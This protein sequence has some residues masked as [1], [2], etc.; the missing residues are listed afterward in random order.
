MSMPVHGTSILGSCSLI[1]PIFESDKKE[2]CELIN[3]P[4]ILGRLEHLAHQSKRRPFEYNASFELPLKGEGRKTVNLSFY[5]NVDRFLTK[6]KERLNSSGFETADRIQFKGGAIH[7]ILDGHP[8]ELHDF[9]VGLKIISPGNPGDWKKIHEIILVCMEDEAGLIRYENT[10]EKFVVYKQKDTPFNIEMVIEVD[11]RGNPRKYL[12]Q[13]PETIKNIW[14]ASESFRKMGEE[15]LLY[16]I[17]TKV[18]NRSCPIE[19]EIVAKHKNSATCSLDA[20]RV[21]YPL[22]DKI[23]PNFSA[24]DGYDAKLILE[25]REKGLFEVQLQRIP[26]IRLGFLRYN[27]ILMKGYLPTLLAFEQAYG[28][29]LVKNERAILDIEKGLENYLKDHCATPEKQ[30]LYL[31][32]SYGTLLRL[33]IDKE[34][35]QRLQEAYGQILCK[36]LDVKENVL[37]LVEDASHLIALYF[38]SFTKEL[39]YKER[40]L[41]RKYETGQLTRYFGSAGKRGNAFV[42]ETSRLPD[43][44]LIKEQLRKSLSANQGLKKICAIVIPDTKKRERLLGEINADENKIKQFLPSISI[45]DFKSFLESSEIQLFP[46]KKQARYLLDLFSF[47]LST[48]VNLSVEQKDGLVKKIKLIIQELKVTDVLLTISLVRNA[49]ELKV[50]SVKDKETELIILIGKLIEAEDF[51]EAYKLCE[52]TAKDSEISFET[53]NSIFQLLMKS[54]VHLKPILKFLSEINFK[55][56]QLKDTIKLWQQILEKICSTPFSHSSMMSFWRL[57]AIFGNDC[58]EA[59]VLDQLVGESDQIIEMT[60]E[61]FKECKDDQILKWAYEVDKRI[62]SPCFEKQ[63]GYYFESIKE[64]CSK[65]LFEGTLEA[66]HRM[67]PLYL[68]CQFDLI[69]EDSNKR[70]LSIFP[71]FIKGAFPYSNEE[72]WQA[73][74]FGI[75]QFFHKSLSVQ[76]ARN[77]FQKLTDDSQFVSFPE[78]L[79]ASWEALGKYCQIKVEFKYSSLGF[80]RSIET[81]LATEQDSDFE[82]C[83][84]I[85]RILKDTLKD[86]SELNSVYCN[87]IDLFTNAL[88]KPEKSDRMMSLLQICYPLLNSTSLGEDYKRMHQ[89]SGVMMDKIFKYFSQK[90]KL[91]AEQLK[92]ARKQ[93]EKEKESILAKLISNYQ[94]QSLKN[95]KDPKIWKKLY[96]FYLELDDGENIV[97]AGNNYL[98]YNSSKKNN[99]KIIQGIAYGYMLAGKPNESHL[100][101]KKLRMNGQQNLFTDYY[102]AYTFYIAEKEIPEAANLAENNNVLKFLIS[103]LKDGL[104]LHTISVY[105]LCALEKLI[106]IKNKSPDLVH[107]LKVLAKTIEYNG[108]KKDQKS[109]YENC[110]LTLKAPEKQE[111]KNDKGCFEEA[112]LDD[113]SKEI[114]KLESEFAKKPKDSKICQK[115]YGCYIK[116]NDYHNIIRIAQNYLSL[117]PDDKIQIT[118]WIGYS[119]FMQNQLVLARLS[120]EYFSISKDKLGPFLSQCL[121]IISKNEFANVKMFYQTMTKNICEYMKDPVS[122][123]FIYSFALGVFEMMVNNIDNM[124]PQ[125]LA[126]LQELAKELHNLNCEL[127]YLVKELQFDVCIK[128]QKIKHEKCMLQF[129]QVKELDFFKPVRLE[130]P[131]LLNELMRFEPQ[132][133]T[134]EEA[135]LVGENISKLEAE[136]KNKP[137]NFE[138][139]KKLFDIYVRTEDHAN[140]IKI[141]TACLKQI[142]S[143]KNEVYEITHCVAFSY[144]LHNEP[145]KS[146]LLF[147]QLSKKDKNLNLLSKFY[148]TVLKLIELND[149][150]FNLSELIEGLKK[151]ISMKPSKYV[152]HTFNVYM[153]SL[154]ELA[155]L[156]PNRA[157][158]YYAS[159]QDLAGLLRYRG[160]NE[161]QK[162]RYGACLVALNKLSKP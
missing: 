132:P 23:F 44:E 116:T 129:S 37:E 8:K 11:G 24:V 148:F 91:S 69:N 45:L 58:K 121:T 13:H 145:H 160:W 133:L 2:G 28:E 47:K 75:N 95:P 39:I 150:K 131:Y 49:C 16:Q 52:F 62:S 127:N 100:L 134:K 112:N 138:I 10:K 122:L 108:W 26:T 50:F 72:I 94:A 14:C 104:L 54:S 41:S 59:C 123:L 56:E 71:A 78:T 87:G 111:A 156:Y 106:K 32:I 60:I 38:D 19:V 139:L 113:L 149:F 1:T 80:K 88:V 74:V 114:L 6:C 85:F 84:D 86:Q 128:D 157:S 9:D 105:A 146:Y 97:Q 147:K 142:D 151:T 141:G 130:D 22:G 5:F 83:I 31:L 109:R 46:I 144:F 136:L 21:D 125:N 53:L 153:L 89:E 34:T 101:L 102:Y 35:K 103:N 30:I 17:P 65:L 63:N 68:H 154:F 3:D 29:H 143:S 66:D 33:N 99:T 40:P 120:F 73:I 18:L 76:I 119:Y 135:I 162:K 158:R 161:D 126:P 140:I 64:V 90:Y 93:P 115:L 82:E 77:V 4:I 152:L 12:F 43:K 155:F 124:P 42:F 7:F 25:L 70:F 92:E 96:G 51:K 118:H 61:F 110:L 36:T 55:K 27:S 20:L 48:L 137:D 67:V 107:A 15:Y 79:R 98:Q 117:L 81:F 159:L 57:F